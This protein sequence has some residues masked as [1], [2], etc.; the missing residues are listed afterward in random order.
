MIAVPKTIDNDTLNTIALG[1][2]SSVAIARE[3]VYRAAA[4]PGSNRCVIVEVMGR[5]MG[6]LALQAANRYPDDL[7][8]LSPS[9]QRKIEYAR[10]TMMTLVPEHVVSIEGI[11]KQTLER[12]RRYG[13]VTVVV[14]EGFKLSKNNPEYDKLILNNLVLAA[15]V[16]DVKEDAHRNL[17]I[18]QG[19]AAEFIAQILKDLNPEIEVLGFTLR[20]VVPTESERNFA[21]GLAKKAA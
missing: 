14:A 15:A 5:N 9:L 11:R 16:K 20:G 12:M 6:S 8:E 19:V 21:R 13:G 18:P 10:P 17:I 3:E 7:K 1:V 4:V 2:L